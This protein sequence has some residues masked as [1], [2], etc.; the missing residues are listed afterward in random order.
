M[1]VANLAELLLCQILCSH[2]SIA[3]DSGIMGNAVYLAKG[4]TTPCRITVPSSLGSSSPR[5]IAMMDDWVFCTRM[6]QTNIRGTDMQWAGSCIL[7]A[8]MSVVW[9]RVGG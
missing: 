6:G 7:A 4:F 5:R 2:C 3:E 9:A 1:V 8:E